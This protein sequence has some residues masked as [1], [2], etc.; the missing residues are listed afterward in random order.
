[1]KKNI[2]LKS[3]HTFGISVKAAKYAEIKSSADLQDFIPL[4]ESFLILGGGSNI[5]FTKDFE[6]LVIH[7]KIRGI[8]IVSENDDK[9]ILQ[10]G[11]G[12]NWHSL[13]LWCIE[14]GY[15][16]I[17]NLSLIP[18]CVGAAPIQNIGAYGVEFKEV[19]H[20]LEAIDLKTG[21]TKIF[22]HKDCQF[23]YR[24]SVFKKELKG[25]FCITSVSI[26]LSKKPSFNISYG[27]IKNIL[28]ASG[29]ELS[30]KAVS[31]AVIKI[32][33]EKLPDPKKIGNSGSFFTNPII[34]LNQLSLLKSKFP[35]IPIYPVGEKEVKI[36]AGWL[37]D[38]LGWKGYRKGDAGV[39]KNQ[40]LVLVNYGN[41]KGV[42]IWNLAKSIQ[43]SVF[44]EY[45]ILLETE[46]NI[47]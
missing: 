9:V 31:N 39:H 35:N 13:V 17:E 22:K 14:K 12:E 40:A 1:M 19:F 43:I 15:G 11:S 47:L 32:R 21:T 5:L 25:K 8:E 37:I 30:I 44:E 42:E 26:C 29:E 6:G 41:A 7:N 2:S 27:V 34:P 45:G 23:G 18:G 16:G 10:I 20:S 24:D 38:H 3:F 28:E 4:Q 46:V 36:A 33:T